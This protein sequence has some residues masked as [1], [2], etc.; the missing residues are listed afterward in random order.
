M[1]NH[2]HAVILSF[3]ARAVINGVIDE[4]FAVREINSLLQN[5]DHTGEVADYFYW[6]ENELERFPTGQVR[7]NYSRTFLNQLDKEKS[8]MLEKTRVDLLE[9]CKRLVE[10]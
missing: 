3:I 9:M 1:D 2:D 8:E 4:I 7:K 6:L 5:D 10:Q